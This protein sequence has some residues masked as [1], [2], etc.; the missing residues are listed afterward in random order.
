MSVVSEEKPFYGWGLRF[1]CIRC[2]ACCRYESGYVFLSAKDVGRLKSAFKMGDEEFIKTYCRWVPSA[3]GSLQLSLKEKSNY[4]CIFWKAEAGAS[5]REGAC[6]VYE[7]RPLQ[8]RT[9]PFWSSVV[10]SS[11]SWEMVAADC[12][13]MGKGVFHSPDTIE[14]L[15]ALRQ[16]EPII[17]KGES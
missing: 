15:L 6:S 5:T 9:F 16:K 10:D 12:P 3:N 17:F 11:E 4:D 8:C 13:G 1:S 7:A 14:K 2:S